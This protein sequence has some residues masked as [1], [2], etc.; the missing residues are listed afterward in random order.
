MSS[1]KLCEE[2]FPAPSKDDIDLP[3]PRWG[4]AMTM[5]NENKV[6][7]YGGQGLDPKTNDFV[8]LK[9]I[10]VY[11]LVKKTWKQPVNC[12]G[13]NRTNCAC[14]VILSFVQLYVQ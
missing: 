13:K 8:T 2:F 4:F 3:S 6:V 14:N 5:I 1:S 10:Y 12:V 9:D 7:V 11:D